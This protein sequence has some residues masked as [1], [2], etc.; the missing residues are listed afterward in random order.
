MAEAITTK[1]AILTGQLWVNVPVLTILIGTLILGYAQGYNIALAYIAGAV[2]A[3][4]Y[5]SLMIPKW[6]KWAIAKGADEEALEKWGRL[7]LLT[8]K[9]GSLLA[10]TE[11]KDKTK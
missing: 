7:T 11:F 8:F 5:W 4:L 3:W 9:K 10:K 1:K 2:P 6:R